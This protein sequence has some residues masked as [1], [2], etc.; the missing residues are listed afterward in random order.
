VAQ[1]HYKMKIE[2]I[3]TY[4]GKPQKIAS[5]PFVLPIL[6][7]KETFLKFAMTELSTEERRQLIKISC[8]IYFEHEGKSDLPDWY[9][10]CNGK[11]YFEN[12]VLQPF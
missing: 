2:F 5:Y 9:D 11:F 10:E 12:G 3:Y 1:I 4:D 7:D 6:Q 8:C